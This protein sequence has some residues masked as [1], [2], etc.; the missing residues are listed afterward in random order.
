M[1]WVGCVGEEIKLVPLNNRHPEMKRGGKQRTR[2]KLFTFYKFSFR[3]T[4]FVRKKAI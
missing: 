1:V 3:H 2:L 4:E